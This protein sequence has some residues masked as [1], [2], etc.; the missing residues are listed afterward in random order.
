MATDLAV[1]S[2]WSMSRSWAETPPKAMDEPRPKRASMAL[3]PLVNRPPTVRLVGLVTNYERP[4]Q[5]CACAPA[6]GRSEAAN[7]ARIWRF[8]YTL[9]VEV[10]G[11]C[12]PGRPRFLD[13][14]VEPAAQRG[15][16]IQVPSATPKKASTS[17]ATA[18]IPSST[19]T[20]RSVASARARLL[21]SPRSFA[22][23]PHAPPAANRR[24]GGRACHAPGARR[25][26][27]TPPTSPVTAITTRSVSGAR[28][29]SDVT[30]APSVG[31]GPSGEEGVVVRC[32]GCSR[33]A[34][35]PR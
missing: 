11:A 22:A 12:E 13:R 24:N 5:A 10:S 18:T 4:R 23:M 7:A 28:R 26:S 35:W 9:R 16:E 25:T 30:R 14:R 32:R 21:V 29:V 1:P 6:S 8:M 17:S 19:A 20:V 2:T 34:R 31:S 15:Y 33:S 3:A 27:A